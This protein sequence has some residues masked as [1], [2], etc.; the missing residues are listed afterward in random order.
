MSNTILLTGATG[1]LGTQIA[2]ELLK[3]TDN[4][5]IALVRGEDED[6]ALRHLQR[7]WWDWP[8]LKKA[9]GERV[10]LVKGDVSKKH[11]GIEK[12]VYENLLEN[13]THIIHTAADLRLDAPLKELQK[14]N[15][16]GTDNILEIAHYAYQD[17][18]LERF[19]H[20]STAYV[21]GR[22]KGVI[23]EDSCTDKYGFLNNYERSKFEGETLVRNSHVPT[24]IFRPGMVVGDSQNGFIKTF[25]TVY[26]PVR[27]YLTGKLQ[28]MPVNPSFKIN[29]IP[30]DY[31]ARAVAD[32]TF[33][34]DAEG[35]T[36][37]LTPPHDLLPT[38]DELIKLIRRWAHTKLKIKLPRPLFIP[39]PLFLIQKLSNINRI[40][41]HGKNALSTLATLAP[42]FSEDRKFLR[43]NTDR[44]IGNY[45]LKWQD[46]LPKLLEYAFYM[47]F[48]HRSDR[49]VHEQIL[50][51]LKSRSR[52]VK[53]YDVVEGKFITPNSTK[54][55]EDMLAAA[56]ALQKIGISPGDRV[57]LVGLNSTRYL[58][59]DV[60][61]GLTGAVSVPIYYT[62]SIDEINEILDASGS[63]ILFVGAPGLLRRLS[64]IEL[65]IPLIS[66][67]RDPV[68]L[69]SVFMT[70]DEF[71]AMGKDDNGE[72]NAPVNFDDVAT[73][74]YTSGTTGKPRGVVFNHGNLRWMAESMASLPPWR[75]R[76]LEIS[77]LSFLPMNHV[78]EG[79]L[80]AY[81]PYYAPAPLK[82]YF[83][84]NFQDLQQTLPQVKPKIFFSVPRFYEKVWI[85]VLESGIGI[86][87]LNTQEGIL[88]G[89]KKKILRK[90]LRRGILKKAG[91]DNC[92]QLIV[93]SA[94]VSSD[95]L[96]QFQDL[97]IEIHNAYGL[98]EAPLLTLNRL[99]E[100]RIGTVGK[101]L[102][103][104]KVLIAPD[105]EIMAKGPQVTPGYF[106]E[107]SNSIFKDGWLLTGDLGHITSEG[108][109]V[110]DGRKKEVIINSYG[111]TIDPLKIEA[112]LRDIPGIS[113]AMV[114]GD[115]K[116][117][118]VA[119][120]WTEQRNLDPAAIDLSI[121][122]VNS[123]ISH[124]EQIKKWVLLKY[125]LSIEGGDLTANLK[126]KRKSIIERYHQIIETIYE[127]KDSDNFLLSGYME[128]DDE[129]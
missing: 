16:G 51:R 28:I 4:R 114:V 48:F 100:N 102:P 1:F 127:N 21:A 53:Y 63:R 120:L 90:L 20:I 7:T 93:G 109:L 80:G 83:L 32:L 65:Q 35:L 76:N 26:V 49:T 54:I 112:M 27:L 68:E 29:F 30:V 19:S 74:R 75:D 56:K 34:P 11:L 128:D 12:T 55:R 125:D 6:A 67:C 24:S 92:A 113:A 98:T 64:E 44:L 96:K 88:A 70:W 123:Q 117:Y 62:S 61:I 94:W 33:H 79:I 115:R 95:L 59:M 85:S 106:N 69:P 97:G 43:D 118:C 13:I 126:L 47:G 40:F 111:K 17:N 66:F 122:R 91:L 37:H 15:V 77:Y 25:N 2:L 9:I 42:Y 101:P 41:G 57:A 22:R 107:D 71:L 124:P 8:E 82:L 129:S 78:V 116:P 104:T 105:G 81:S 31:V 73:L 38:V 89:F 52:P 84:E 23:E 46:F 14:I 60:A 86:I 119:L 87:Y 3:Q 103:S 72:I 45:N 39:L 58:I 108:N 99:G 18:L 121:N 50:F 110:I 10:Q 36:F 5:I